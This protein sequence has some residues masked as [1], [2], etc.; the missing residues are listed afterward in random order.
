MTFLTASC[1][2][3]RKQLKGY[4]HFYDQSLAPPGQIELRYIFFLD[5]RHASW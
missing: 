3:Y 4:K 2:G 1:C 5:A